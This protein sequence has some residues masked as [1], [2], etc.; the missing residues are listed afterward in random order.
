VLFKKTICPSC[1]ERKKK[2]ETQIT[3]R[4]I[5]DLFRDEPNWANFFY[6]GK[7]D[8]A[9]DSLTRGTNWACDACLKDGKALNAF[10]FKQ[11]FC[12][13]PP[14]LA[15]ID[16]ENQCRTCQCC[17][18]FSKQ[19]KKYWYEDLN[20]WV[21]S[22]AVNCKECRGKQRKR[23]VNIK[24]AQ[25]SLAK[26]LPKV[27]RSNPLYL[28]EIIALYEITESTNKV[29]EYTNILKKALSNAE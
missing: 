29:K 19:E 12:D 18:I 9:Y 28:R 10:P 7:I 3:L 4:T 1:R 26:L 17:F 25:D 22:D 24:G 21:Q 23:K 14:Y 27:D 6:G 5:E 8:K 13:Y 15:Y 11:T 20:F 16:S 2:S